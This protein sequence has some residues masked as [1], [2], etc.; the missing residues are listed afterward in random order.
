MSPIVNGCEP[1]VV[2]DA[3][4]DRDESVTR[5]IPI[6]QSCDVVLVGDS[7][8][9][10]LFTSWHVIIWFDIVGGVSDSRYRTSNSRPT[11]DPIT[12]SGSSTERQPVIAY[13]VYVLQSSGRHRISSTTGNTNTCCCEGNHRVAFIPASIP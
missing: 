9:I 13:V 11:M 1:R 3:S 2:I 4:T 6:S 10:D 12:V 5:I 8:P 7:L